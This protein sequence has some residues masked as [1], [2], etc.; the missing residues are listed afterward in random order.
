MYQFQQRL[1][2]LKAHIKQWNQTTFG[3]IF[4]AQKALAQ[5]I[6]EI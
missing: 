4:Q 2:H 1:K 6:I 3:N 5:E